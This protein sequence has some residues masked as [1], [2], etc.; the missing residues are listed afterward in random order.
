MAN[1][2]VQAE[3]E[4]DAKIQ[5]EATR[6]LDDMGITVSQALRMMLMHIAREKRLPFAVGQETLEALHEARSGHLKRYK[7]V[8]D[9][10]DDLDA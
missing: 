4:V 3:A 5:A 9:M 1:Q 2:I 7:N 8:A 6:V 10:L